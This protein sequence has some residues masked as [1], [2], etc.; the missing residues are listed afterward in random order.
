MVF[1]NYKTFNKLDLINNKL[2]LWKMTWNKARGNITNFCI[3][4]WRDVEHLTLTDTAWK[5]SRYGV[6]SDPYFPAFGFS[7]Q[8]QESTDQKK[9]RIWTFFTQCQYYSYKNLL[10]FKMMILQQKWQNRK[11]LMYLKHC[12]QW[13]HQI[14][15][16]MPNTLALK[17]HFS[18]KQMHTK[19]WWC[20]NKN[21]Q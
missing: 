18:T 19:Y 1:K 10:E 13:P 21:S 3:P 16:I 11:I 7:V 14:I 2:I 4:N 12:N 5:V 15:E 20:K 17:H 9:L 8:I 6:F